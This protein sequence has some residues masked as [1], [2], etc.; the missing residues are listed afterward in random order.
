VDILYF[1]RVKVLG[2]LTM[3]F[4]G[5]IGEKKKPAFGRAGAPT[6]RLVFGMSEEVRKVGRSERRRTS[7]ETQS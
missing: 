2:G 5:E 6:A 4:A 7:A 3:V 1:V